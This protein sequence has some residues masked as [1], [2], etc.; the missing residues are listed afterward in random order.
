MPD[1]SSGWRVSDHA[2]RR[3]AELG[4][5]LLEVVRV[6]THPSQSYAQPNR[7]PGYGVRQG[8]AFAL[9]VHEPTRTVLSVLRRDVERWEHALELPAPRRV[10]TR[11][12][13]PV[14]VGRVPVEVRRRGLRREPGLDLADARRMLAEGYALGQVARLT[15]YP[16]EALEALEAA[17]RSG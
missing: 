12:A 15:G 13:P 5:D 16:V 1:V 17:G 8:P 11:V 10:P 14:R 7:G 4:V 2:R 6:A 9:G 3:A